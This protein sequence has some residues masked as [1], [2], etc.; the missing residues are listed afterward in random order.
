M[1][2][3]GLYEKDASGASE[4]KLLLKARPQEQF[5]PSSFDGR[6]LLYTVIG[7][8]GGFDLWVLSVD[9]ESKPIPFLATDFNER[10]ANSLPTAGGSLT[11]RTNRAVMKSMCG[12]FPR[13]AASGQCRWPAGQNLAGGAT[14]GRSTTWR[15]VTS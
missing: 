15:Q 2:G 13:R 8:K 7:P 4:G 9:G 14:E 11:S 10:G 3:G 12:D 5:F 1:G 6:H